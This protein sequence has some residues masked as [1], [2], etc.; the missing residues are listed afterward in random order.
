MALA[1]PSVLWLESE[2]GMGAS[3]ETPAQS[4]SPTQGD[5]EPLRA[6]PVAGISLKRCIPPPSSQGVGSD[7]RAWRQEVEVARSHWDI[8]IVLALN[9]FLSESWA[10]ASDKT[11]EPLICFQLGDTFSTP[12]VTF[13]AALAHPPSANAT[14]ECGPSRGN[15]RCSL[16]ILE[17][18]G[19]THRG[20]GGQE[21]KRVKTV[22][23]AWPRT[24]DR[25]R[26]ARESQ[27]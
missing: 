25:S 21:G 24:E 27:R 10:E 19:F 16:S 5:Q 4:P 14:R 1:L 13:Q 9:K 7:W 15:S 11:M 8:K 17:K 20:G 26:G 12:S 2:A 3:Q 23:Q 18:Q 22:T 6:K